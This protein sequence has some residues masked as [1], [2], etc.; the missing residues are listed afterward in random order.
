M[1]GS[2]VGVVACCSDEEP[3]QC[4]ANLSSELPPHLAPAIGDSAEAFAQFV[5][6]E[7]NGGKL[8]LAATALALVW[9]NVAHDAY[10]SV[11]DAQTQL[12][13]AWLELNLTLGD[14]APTG[15]WRCSSLSPGW[16]SSAS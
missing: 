1:P 13:P 10:T 6:E 16:S 9:A 8:L 3:D 15:C 2:P 11:W 14:W 12:G 5:R 7:T 4:P